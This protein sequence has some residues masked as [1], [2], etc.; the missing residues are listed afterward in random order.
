M[1]GSGKALVM[2]TTSPFLYLF[3]PT[4]DTFSEHY[5]HDGYYQGD[6]TVTRMR[7]TGATLSPVIPILALDGVVWFQG[8]QVFPLGS[9]SV[10]IDDYADLGLNGVDDNIGVSSTGVA[11]VGVDDVTERET[12]APIEGDY[13]AIRIQV[14]LMDPQGKRLRQVTVISDGQ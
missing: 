12:R 11:N 6:E 7:A 3:Q 2:G 5:E 13:S 4:F 14:R 1:Y 9:V 8:G 10:A